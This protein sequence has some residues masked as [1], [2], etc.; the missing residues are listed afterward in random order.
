MADPLTWTAAVTGKYG[1][2]VA[3]IVIGTAARYGLTLNEGRP[4]TW[5]GILGDFLLLGMLGLIAIAIADYFEL[6]GNARVLTGALAAV[7]SDRLVRLV[8]ASFLARVQ[9]AIA[10][11]FAT[12]FG[13]TLPPPS[14]PKGP[15]DAG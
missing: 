3:G 6:A 12:M 10:T 8:R 11:L 7:S 13:I 4:L 9:A 5:R 14:N 15:S 2:T 1:P